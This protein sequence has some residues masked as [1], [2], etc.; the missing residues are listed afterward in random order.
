MPYKIGSTAGGMVDLALLT[1]PVEY[2]VGKEHYQPYS[3]YKKLGSGFR[4]GYGLPRTRWVWPLITQEERD[5]LEAFFPTGSDTVFISTR[6]P[7][8]SFVDYE[9]VGNW[10][11]KEPGFGGGHLKNFV[12]EFEHMEVI[13]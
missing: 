8:D 11:V 2:P 9:C 4:R 12:I 5:Q 10:I 1:V 7:D 6:L 3:L 13:P